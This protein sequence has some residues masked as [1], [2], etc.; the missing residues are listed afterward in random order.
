METL[1]LNDQEQ[2][3]YAELFSSCD[4]DNTGKIPW[5]K[6]SEVFRASQLSPDILQKVCCLPFICYNVYL[7]I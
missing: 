6:A 3:W 2:R 5:A 4:V 7:S 1:K